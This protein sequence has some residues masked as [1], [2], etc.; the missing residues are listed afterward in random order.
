M[1]VSVL[2]RVVIKIDNKEDRSHEISSYIIYYS[3]YVFVEHGKIMLCVCGQCATPM[4]LD[5]P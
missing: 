4:I 3:R 5:S 1:Y 2:L